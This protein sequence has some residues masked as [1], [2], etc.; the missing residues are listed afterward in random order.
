MLWCNLLHMIK[1]YKRKH[2]KL[3]KRKHNIFLFY[4]TFHNTS[5]KL[6]VSYPREAWNVEKQKL[7]KQGAS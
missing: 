6:R 7:G 3:Y 4:N 2:I 1:L 5:L